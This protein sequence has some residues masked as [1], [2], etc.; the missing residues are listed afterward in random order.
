MS[1]LD[2]EQLRKAMANPT[3]IRHVSIISHSNR[4]QDLMIDSH[5][6]KAGIY[7]RRQLHTDFC[8]DERT[9]P[10]AI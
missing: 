4:Q 1:L 9:S 6:L 3:N 10:R 7:F 2:E 5:I 8:Y